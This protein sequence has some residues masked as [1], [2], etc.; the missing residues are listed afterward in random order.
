[1]ERADSIPRSLRSSRKSFAANWGPR[2]EMILS[3]SPNRR[4]SVSCKIFAVPSASMVLLQ[5]VRITPFVR[6]W[7][8]T[9]KI[10]SKLLDSGRSVMKSVDTWAKGRFVVGFGLGTSVTLVG[11]R[12]I[13][14]CWHSAH[15]F[16]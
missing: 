11:W 6:P 3:G 15:P 9:T 2:S 12:L 16:T 4:K 7:S 14:N 8:T 5:G 10:E 1:M 13:L